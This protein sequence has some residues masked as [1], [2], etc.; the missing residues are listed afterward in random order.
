MKCQSRAGV[1]IISPLKVPHPVS[2]GLGNEWPG[3][4][5]GSSLGSDRVRRWV[6]NE[7]TQC[8]VFPKTSPKLICKR[9][10]PQRA[11]VERFRVFER[12]LFWNARSGLGGENLY[13][14][15][16]L[17]RRPNSG[18][19]KRSEVFAGGLMILRWIQV[20]WTLRSQIDTPKLLEL[21]HKDIV[22]FGLCPDYLL[23]Q[24]GLQFGDNLL[25]PM[26]VF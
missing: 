15:P 12:T 20:R 25:Y 3:A 4:G 14:P 9:L 7:G 13:G 22:L 1:S 11:R 19:R 26:L 18:A 5:S 17:H 23:V 21:L 2:P 10:I 24:G 8:S 16:R 6:P